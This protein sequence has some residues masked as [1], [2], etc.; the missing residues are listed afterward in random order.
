MKINYTINNTCTRDPSYS[1]WSQHEIYESRSFHIILILLLIYITGV[2]VHIALFI[3]SFFPFLPLFPL[4]PP[5]L[6]IFLLMGGKISIICILFCD[7]V[8]TFIINRT[9]NNNWL[10]L[11]MY[12][13]FLHLFPIIFFHCFSTYL[14]SYT[15]TS[16]NLSYYIQLILV[17]C[18]CIIRN[19]FILFWLIHQFRFSY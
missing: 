17:T 2:V 11:H 14:L 6:F 16:P 3:Y 1:Q 4:P 19:N 13:S 9:C 10:S 18:C 8:V 12:I 5:S 15:I 7:P